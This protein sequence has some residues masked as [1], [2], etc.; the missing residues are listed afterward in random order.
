[1]GRYGSPSVG[2]PDSRGWLLPVLAAAGVDGR[3]SRSGRSL[4]MQI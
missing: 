1:M 4:F 3:W 2:P